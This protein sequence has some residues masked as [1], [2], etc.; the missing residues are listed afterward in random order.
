[1]GLFPGSQVGQERLGVD[2]FQSAI[3][4]GWEK[5]IHKPSFPTSF[6]SKMSSLLKVKVDGVGGILI[7]CTST[8]FEPLAPV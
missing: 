7:A 1:M 6:L 8:A 5:H 4:F 3:P 2:H